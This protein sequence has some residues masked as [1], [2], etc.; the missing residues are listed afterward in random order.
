MKIQRILLTLAIL[1]VMIPINVSGYT[2]TLTINSTEGGTVTASKTSD[3]AYNTV[4]T[5]TVAVTDGYYLQSLEYEE[6]M[7]LGWAEAPKRRVTYPNIP[8]VV[9]ILALS[10]NQTTYNSTAGAHHA[11]DYTFNMPNNNVIVR[12]VFGSLKSFADSGQTNISFALGEGTSSEMYN[13]YAHTLVVKDSE[14]QLTEGLDYQITGM[15]YDPTS[16]ATGYTIRNAG[17]YTVTITGRGKYQGSKTSETL[18]I[19]KAPL[20]IT[21]QAKSKKY[22]EADPALT[23]TSSGT[24][25]GDGNAITGELTREA[26]ENAGTYEIQQGSVNAVNYTIT[27]YGANL[28]INPLAA[29]DESTETKAIV[30]LS[31]DAANWT[32]SDYSFTYTG[33]ALIPSVLVTYNSTHLTENIDYTLATT[34]HYTDA[35]DKSKPDIYTVTVNFTG[36]YSGLTTKEYQIRKD[37]TLSYPYRWCTHYETEV[38]M[39]V[40]DGVKSYTFNTLDEDNNIVMLDEQQYIKKNVPMLLYRTGATYNNFFPVVVKSDLDALSSINGGSSLLG[41]STATAVSGLVSAHSDKDIWILVNDE[42]VR[43]TTGT[44]PANKCYLV[45]N[46]NTIPVPMLSIRRNT[47]GID[48][49]KISNINLNGIWYTLD[50]RR[51]QGIP[52][53]KG[54]YINNGKKIIIK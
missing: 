28:V 47:T 45:L 9:N 41:T 6:V 50:G 43:T 11:G 19:T 37:I 12:A 52:A 34:G 49:N 27:Y 21:A 29:G 30:T 8:S 14:T 7:D 39:E 15:T 17:A 24:V 18:T 33:A 16:I 32:A 4:I 31:S 53:K 38:N 5:L 25:Y 3:I 48:V 51:L 46:K 42:F 2:Y 20:T 23:Y 13:G 54:I 1:L 10:Q 26:G 44:I 22:G 40:L 35:S 36:N